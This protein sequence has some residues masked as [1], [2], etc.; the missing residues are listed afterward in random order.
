MEQPAVQEIVT[1][2]GRSTPAHSSRALS[3]IQRVGNRRILELN[4][5]DIGDRGGGGGRTR[6]HEQPRGRSE[7]QADGRH[8]S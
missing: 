4:G 6:S 8:I 5:R 3:W 7:R 1:R 2:L